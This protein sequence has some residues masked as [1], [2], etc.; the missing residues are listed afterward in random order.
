ML[1]WQIMPLLCS[2]NPL[3]QPRA[4]SPILHPTVPQWQGAGILG[5]QKSIWWPKSLSERPGEACRDTVASS[6]SN[7]WLGDAAIPPPSHSDLAVV[8]QSPYSDKSY[9]ATRWIVGIFEPNFT[10]DSYLFFIIFDLCHFTVE[11]C[12]IRHKPPQ[13]SSLTLHQSLVFKSL[14]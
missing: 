7:S 13:L 2:E 14:I 8:L 9:C 5:S 1:H 10:S 12:M 4:T 11:I 6:I 3:P